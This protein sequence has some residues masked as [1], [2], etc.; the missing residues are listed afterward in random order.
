LC[1][2]V[3]HRYQN[4]NWLSIA[5]VVGV[6]SF[7][8]DL[9]A[10]WCSTRPVLLLDP[11]RSAMYIW[12]LAGFLGSLVTCTICAAEAL[13]YYRASARTA[14]LPTVPIPRPF[15]VLFR[16]YAAVS[17]LRHHIAIYIG[18]GILTRWPS[19]CSLRAADTHDGYGTHTLYGTAFKPLRLYA[20]TSPPTHGS[21]WTE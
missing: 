3:L 18:T 15:N 19:A 16:Q 7:P 12:S 8:V 14:D 21:E 5:L 1:W 4:I 2:A 11:R 10:Y 9:R 17:L 20:C 6:Y 13:Q